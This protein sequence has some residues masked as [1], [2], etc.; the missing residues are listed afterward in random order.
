MRLLRLADKY[1]AYRAVG[2]LIAVL[3]ECLRYGL[4]YETC[5]K[6]VSQMLQLAVSMDNATLIKAAKSTIT[7]HMNE[8]CTLRLSLRTCLTLRTYLTRMNAHTHTH[9]HTH[10]TQHV[11]EVRAFRQ[12]ESRKALLSHRL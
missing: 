11:D 1:S 2:E 10:I 6:R 12:Y 9:T 5:A 4:T 7:Q 8:V 3:T